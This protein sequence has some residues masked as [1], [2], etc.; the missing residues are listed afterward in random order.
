L[1]T[2]FN[3]D[4]TYK[5]GGGRVA[6]YTGI[7]TDGWPTDTGDW[8]G[9]NARLYSAGQL[10]ALDRLTVDGASNPVDVTGTGNAGTFRVVAHAPPTGT[11]I[12]LR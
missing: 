5:S 9:E 6:V 2:W 11:V 3:P 4:V 1:A 10:N 12:T 7:L 8:V